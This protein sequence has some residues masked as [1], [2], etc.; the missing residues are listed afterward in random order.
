[1]IM[2]EIELTVEDCT[3]IGS[4]HT[5]SYLSGHP[6]TSIP[7]IRS[8]FMATRYRY[9]ARYFGKELVQV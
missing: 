4:K 5:G 3:L 2:F 8:V 6:H 1:M 7:N 9:K